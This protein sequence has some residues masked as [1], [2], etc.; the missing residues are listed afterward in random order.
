MFSVGC[1]CHSVSPQVG[2]H[3]TI[4][5]D[6]WDLTGPT[7]LSL[8]LIIPDIIPGIPRPLNIRPGTP[9]PEPPATDIWW[10]ML[11]TCS[12]LFTWGL[13]RSGIWWWSLMYVWFASRW[14]AISCYI[15]ESEDSRVASKRSSKFRSQD[16][17]K[18]RS[19]NEQL[20]FS[21]FFLLSGRLVVNK[22]LF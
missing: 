21:T 20:I 9:S 8:P 4:T 15:I 7:Y 22:S 6:A 13:P 5:H 1:V 14:Y 3:V 18:L 17:W 10:E 11:E 12:N 2:P 16:C 19:F